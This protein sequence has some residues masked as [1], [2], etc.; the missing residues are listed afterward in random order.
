MAE[1]IQYFMVTFDLKDST[2][3]TGEY[4]KVADRLKLV[5]G[6]ENC[7][8]AIRQCMFV[9]TSHT[10]QQIRSQMRQ[11]IGQN[12]NILIIEVGSQNARGFVD[13]DRKAEAARLFKQMKRDGA[14]VFMAKPIDEQSRKLP[15]K[16]P[17]LIGLR[18]ARK[19]TKGA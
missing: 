11:T 7:F 10:P 4:S 14:K 13:L 5:H 17:T 1:N 18:P 8:E 3:R 19:P 12:C 15:P 9:R 6:Q 16:G 2:G